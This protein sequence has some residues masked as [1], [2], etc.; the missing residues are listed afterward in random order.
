MRRRATATY[1]S[2]LLVLLVVATAA[3]FVQYRSLHPCDWLRVDAGRQSQLPE[4]LLRARLR[5]LFLLRGV[6]EPGPVDCLTEWWRVRQRG[7][8]SV[9]PAGSAAP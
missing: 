3:T 1:V 9:E 7:L 8:P 5:G 6:V 4:Q 2:L